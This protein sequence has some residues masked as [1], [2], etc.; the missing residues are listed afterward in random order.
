GRRTPAREERLQGAA[1]PEHGE[2]DAGSV[3]LTRAQTATEDAEAGRRCGAKAQP[4][5]GDQMSVNRRDFLLLRAGQPAVLSCGPL[6]M[7]YL[8]SQAD[9]STSRLFDQ[10]AADLRRVTVVHVADASWRAREDFDR[11]LTAVLDAFT[12]RGGTVT[13]A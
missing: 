6:F 5:D 2:A 3:R 10:L 13:V 12:A 9:G 4:S 8:D 7:R 1:H 11:H